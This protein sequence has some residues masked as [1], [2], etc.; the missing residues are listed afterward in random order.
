MLRRS[1]ERARDAI[2]T[3]GDEPALIE[4]WVRWL[5]EDARQVVSEEV[6]AAAEAAAPFDQIWQGLARYWRKRVEREGAG[7]LDAPLR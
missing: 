1:A 3:G 6:A 2:K 4:A 7:V 5:R